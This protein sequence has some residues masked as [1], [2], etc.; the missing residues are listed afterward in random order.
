MSTYFDDPVEQY[1]NCEV[2]LGLLHRT[3]IDIAELICIQSRRVKILNRYLKSS[4]SK[5]C[6]RRKGRSSALMNDRCN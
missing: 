6:F 4:I 2:P 3:M 1:K 5:V